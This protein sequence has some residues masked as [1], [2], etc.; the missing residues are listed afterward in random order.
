MP[1]TVQE[2]EDMAMWVEGKDGKREQALKA[3]VGGRPINKLTKEMIQGRAA[4]KNKP[5]WQ[6]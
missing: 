6:K 1:I 3:P 5:W 4:K 2:D